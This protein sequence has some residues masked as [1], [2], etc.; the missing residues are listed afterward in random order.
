VSKRRRNSRIRRLGETGP[1]SETEKASKEFW[2][3]PGL[4]PDAPSKIQITEDAAAV[5]RSLGEPPLTGQEEVA[6]HYFDAVYQ[7]S[8]TLASA[9]AA[10]AELVGDDEDDPTV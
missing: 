3:G 5:I 4:L 6:E 10:A 8:V 2:H 9:L 1:N 7:R